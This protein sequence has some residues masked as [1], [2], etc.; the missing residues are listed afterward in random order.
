MDDIVQAHDLTFRKMITAEQIAERVQ[1]MGT[2]LARD[3]AGRHPLFLVVLKGAYMFAAD[4]L[5]ACPI[6][7][8]VAFV[9]LSSYQGTRSSGTVRMDLEMTAK[10]TDRQVII[11]EDIVDTGRTLEAFRQK[12]LADDPADLK[13]ATLLHK[14]EAQAFDLIP[15][16]VGF[17][18]PN[19]FVIGY[20]LDYDEAGR[21]L[22]AI[23]QRT[24]T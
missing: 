17:T 19:E 2:Q 12:L 22:P 7:Q 15:D 18:I 8:E 10:V 16:Y 20:G 6:D 14:P 23:Y 4:L 1:E 3:F 11:V 24:D 5:R 9:R 21:H 13:I